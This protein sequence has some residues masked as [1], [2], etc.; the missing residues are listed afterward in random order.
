[1]EIPKQTTVQSRAVQRIYKK[2]TKTNIEGNKRRTRLT[3]T[4][5]H[6]VTLCLFVTVYAVG[7]R[8]NEA[9]H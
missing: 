7:L 1:M 2:K 5:L 3:P 4:N 8:I 9:E 6:K